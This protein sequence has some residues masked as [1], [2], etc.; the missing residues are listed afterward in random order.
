[1]MMQSGLKKSEVMY[2]NT[3]DCWAKI[4]KNEGVYTLT[5][6]RLV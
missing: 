6:L 5:V 1:M 4:Y 3:A 2:K